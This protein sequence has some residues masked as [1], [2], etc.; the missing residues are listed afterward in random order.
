M[1]F[2]LY[3][4]IVALPQ[5]IS[6]LTHSNMANSAYTHTTSPKPLLSKMKKT[7][8]RAEDE[9]NIITNNIMFDRRVVRGN[10]YAAQVVTHNTQREVE[11][12]RYESERTLRRDATC[13]RKERLAK[14]STP[15]PAEGRAHIK[16]QTDTFLEELS[17]R[18]VESEAVTQ[19]EAILDRPPSP[20]FIPSKTGVDKETDIPGGDLFDFDIEV[21]P[22]LEVLVGK[23]LRVSMMEV[24]EEAELDAIQRRQM[25]FEQMRNAELVEVQRL[26]AEASRR[27]AEK[28]RRFTQ[29]TDRLRQQAELGQK[30]AARAFARSYLANLSELAFDQLEDSGH[31]VDPV[32]KE[33]QDSFIPW[34]FDSVVE[35]T[36][37]HISS[38]S[39]VDALIVDAIELA[40]NLQSD[41]IK[42][43]KQKERARV[44]AVEDAQEIKEAEGTAK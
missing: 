41:V 44:F 2:L 12:M 34:L 35:T 10:T 37:N 9:E 8:Y 39:C 31:F 42:Q 33:I 15:P 13:Q 4:D 16:A 28:Q 26:D 7:T 21:K 19:T 24:M 11:R 3:R 20:L 18:P 43:I 14:P 40:S 23:T 5:Y 38:S 22:I 25:E 1:Y 30:V 6:K 32:E 17:D 27:F 36:N 29:E